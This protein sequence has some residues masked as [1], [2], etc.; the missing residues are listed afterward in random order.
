MIIYQAKEYLPPHALRKI[1]N[2]QDQLVDKSSE[3]VVTPATKTQPTAP[4]RQPQKQ[5]AL[6]STNFGLT[7]PLQNGARAANLLG[8]S[9]ISAGDKF[10]DLIV[11][12]ALAALV[13]AP[14]T[15]I[16]GMG[17]GH[18][19]MTTLDESK[20]EKLRVELEDILAGSCP[21]CESVVTGLDKPFISEGEVD[22]GWTL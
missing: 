22:S 16:P 2:L 7:N 3:N 13:M 1:V 9:V 21:L 19:P 11:P 17:G 18:R 14:A 15:W 8:R 12:D 6:L 20:L 10:R 5:R 4:A